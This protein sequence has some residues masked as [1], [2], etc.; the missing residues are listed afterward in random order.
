MPQSR[1]QFLSRAR[2]AAK[3]LIAAQDHLGGWGLKLSQQAPSIVNTSEALYF[4]ASIGETCSPSVMRGIEYINKN[5]R[6]HTQLRQDGGRGENTRFPAFAIYGLCQYAQG[7]IDP[8]S[9]ETVEWCLEWLLQHRTRDGWP[10]L[11]G[12]GDTSI[13]QTANTLHSLSLA[14]SRLKEMAPSLSATR[15]A[16]IKKGIEVLGDFATAGLLRHRRGDG[17]WP[18]TTFAQRGASPA[19]TSL[20]LL[21]LHAMIESGLDLALDAQTRSALRAGLLDSAVRLA[22]D[23]ARWE[24]YIEGDPEVPGTV[25]QH[26]AYAMALAAACRCGVDP[27]SRSLRTA[28]RY[29]DYSWSRDAATWL[30]PDGS[31]TV[32]IAFHVARAYSTIGD[33]EYKDHHEIHAAAQPAFKTFIVDDCCIMIDLPSDRVSVRLPSRLWELAS[34]VSQNPEGVSSAVIAAKMGLAQRGIARYISRLNDTVA[35]STNDLVTQLVVADRKSGSYRL[36]SG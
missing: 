25:W 14:Y 3:T 27:G 32:R 34:I 13:H 17:L 28:W 24:N 4:F 29:V 22:A 26:P 18:P 21:A 19:K 10:E 11:S 16:S 23:H 36:A 7:F 6:L 8:R 9:I 15:H 30:E 1:E 20:A 35:R 33:V 2:L 5:V 12:A 31:A